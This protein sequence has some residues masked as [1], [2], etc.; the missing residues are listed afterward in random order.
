MTKPNLRGRTAQGVSPGTNVVASHPLFK[1]LVLGDFALVILFAVG[2]L[3][4]AAD[5]PQSALKQN[6]YGDLQKAMFMTLGAFLGLIGGKSADVV[7]V[8]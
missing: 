6:L 2:M 1:W 7:Q 8:T 5:E 3:W 4:C